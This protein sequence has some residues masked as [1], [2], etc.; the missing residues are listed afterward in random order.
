MDDPHARH[1]GLHVPLNIGTWQIRQASG[2]PKSARDSGK[3][4]S[5]AA[6]LPSPSRLMSASSFGMRTNARD[7][8]G[9]I[10][11]EMAASSTDML[12]ACNPE[13]AA[14]LLLEKLTL[15]LCWRSVS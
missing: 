4:F 15:N 9:W 13:S 7:R 2:L 10:V 6:C 14:W 1:T 3:G 12:A 11:L 5:V 8:M